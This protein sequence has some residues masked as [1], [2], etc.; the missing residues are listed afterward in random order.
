MKQSGEHKEISETCNTYKGL[1]ISCRGPW[2]QSGLCSSS[3]VIIG[4]LTQ[5]VAK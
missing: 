2:W 1:V 5:L 3:T 4:L